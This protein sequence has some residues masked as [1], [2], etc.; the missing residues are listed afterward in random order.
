MQK[1]MF[2]LY[3][4]LCDSRGCHVGLYAYLCHE[5]G[6]NNRHGL[7]RTRAGSAADFGI[8]YRRKIIG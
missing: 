2:F 5:S 8:L 7:H 3:V 4:G 1:S 6:H